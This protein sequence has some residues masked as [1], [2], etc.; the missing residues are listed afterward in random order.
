VPTE[1]REA[2]LTAHPAA[3][4]VPPRLEAHHKAEAYLDQADPEAVRTAL[5]LAWRMQRR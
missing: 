4:G 5:E 3:F 1:E 2:L